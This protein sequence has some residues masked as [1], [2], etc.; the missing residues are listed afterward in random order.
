MSLG[1]CEELINLPGSIYNLSSLQTLYLAG[2]LKL[3]GFLEVK[4]DI[5]YLEMLYSSEIAIEELPSSIRNLKTL[6]H[7]NLGSYKELVSLSGSICKL[8]SLQSLYLV[9]CS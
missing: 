8:S 1:F 4:D 6:Q 2:C 3:K 5:E 7:L 9:G